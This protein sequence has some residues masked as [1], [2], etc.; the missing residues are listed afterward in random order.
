MEVR[1]TPNQITIVMT[2]MQ[3]R[4]DASAVNCKLNEFRVGRQQISML[5]A[6]PILPTCVRCET[7]GLVTEFVDH[8]IDDVLELDHDDRDTLDGH[9]RDC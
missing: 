3:L 4:S 7:E 2:Q 5:T 8:S 9:G 1:R 6:K